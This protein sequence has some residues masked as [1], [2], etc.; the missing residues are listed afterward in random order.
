M[1]V[2]GSLRQN[3]GIRDARCQ[4]HAPKNVQKLFDIARERILIM[5]RILTHVGVSERE[6]TAGFKMLKAPLEDHFQSDAFETPICEK[7]NSGADLPNATAMKQETTSICIIVE[8]LRPHGNFTVWFGYNHTACNKCTQGKDVSVVIDDIRKYGQ[9]RPCRDHADDADKKVLKIAQDHIDGFKPIDSDCFRLGTIVSSLCQKLNSLA[10]LSSAVPMKQEADKQEAGEQVSKQEASEQKPSSTKHYYYIVQAN[11]ETA[12]VQ[13]F[14]SYPNITCLGCKK[15]SDVLIRFQAY[16]GSSSVFLCG[17]CPALYN[18]KL[19]K[20]ARD[21]IAIM[22]REIAAADPEDRE[23]SLALVAVEKMTVA[24][25]FDR[26]KKEFERHAR[27]LHDKISELERRE[28]EMMQAPIRSEA[29][30]V[31]HHTMINILRSE[32]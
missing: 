32:P 21:R 1:Y 30:I 15:W 16:P 8:R 7:M 5:D 19:I 10:D 24:E 13:R 4:K 11:N 23:K 2:N 9:S 14:L 20:A 26:L 31:K 18:L 29:D 17:N 22:E 3:D 27:H 25:E 12:Y 28:K 6:I